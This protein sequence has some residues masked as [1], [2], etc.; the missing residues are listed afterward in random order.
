MEYRQLGTTDMR[1]SVIATGGYPF[2]PPLLTGEEGLAPT[3]E[4]FGPSAGR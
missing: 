3:V 1:V 4:G 2:G